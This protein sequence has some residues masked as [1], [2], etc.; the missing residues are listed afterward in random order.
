MALLAALV[1]AQP[2]IAGAIAGVTATTVIVRPSRRARAPSVRP[3]G[4]CS[5]TCMQLQIS[6]PCVAPPPPRPPP[7]TLQQ[8][9]DFVKT[10]IQLAGEGSAGKAASPLA[11]AR[12]ALRTEGPA[13]FYAGYS[14]AATRQIVYGSARLGLFRVFSD[15]LR[16]AR[17]S[18]APLPLWLK[19]AAGLASGAVSS[20]V[21]NP[22]DLALVRMQADAT[23][24]PGERR[25]YT[26]VVDACRRVVRDEGVLALWRGST[27]TVARA[28]ALN[29]AMLATA[30][31]VKEALA[32]HLGG[33]AS[34]PNLV[35]SS[36]VA[37]V[38]ASVAS[39]PFD[40][41]KTRL[42]K[43]RARADGSLPYAGF[44]D[45]FRQIVAKEGPGALYKGLPTY[46]ARI[47]PH[48]FIT[49]L[50]LQAANEQLSRLLL[51]PPAAA[52][53]AAPAGASSGPL[54]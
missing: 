45:C 30:D 15:E 13:A 21:G 31:Q 4:G 16:A 3:C 18:D 32:P 9:I 41:V 48:A 26:G 42:Q 22:F 35:A 2:F 47:G 37:G 44:V 34:L 24:P 1:S 29:A 11:V 23:L 54:R 7:R 20:F 5:E 8:P 52:A 46:V 10:R 40:M 49:L 27:P 14:A 12:E 17:G 43:Q 39:L 33:L 28:M 51:P 53:A 50:V 38:A 25:G 36:L 6:D 19:A